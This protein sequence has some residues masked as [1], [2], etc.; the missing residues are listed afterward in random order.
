MIKLIQN[1]VIQVDAT[2]YC[3]IPIDKHPVSAK[4]ILA[5]ERIDYEIC[6]G[7]GGD[8]VA[9]APLH[10]FVALRHERQFGAGLQQRRQFARYRIDG[11]TV[12]QQFRNDAVVHYQ[13]GER[14]VFNL[15]Q[16]RHDVV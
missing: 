13:V 12:Q 1:R 10:V 3:K 14:H 15:Q 7:A 6:G 9:E 4:Y 16:E 5:S 11:A 2:D 8:G